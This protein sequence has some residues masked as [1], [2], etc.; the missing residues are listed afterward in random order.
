MNEPF[1]TSPQP[2]PEHPAHAYFARRDEEKRSLKRQS[3]RAGICAIA[4]LLLEH[5]LSF[6][7]VGSPLFALYEQSET[8]NGIIEMFFYL[9]CMFCPF[10]VAYCLMRQEDRQM[11]TLFEKPTSK[12]AAAAAVVAGLLICS[13]ANY[14]TNILISLMENAGISV[15]GGVYDTPTTGVSLVYSL[16]TIGILP[17]F[18]E[19]FALRGIVMQPLRRHGDRFAI[20]MSACVFGLLH[21]NLSQ[22]LFAFIV[23]LA[24]GF[25]VVETGS[26]WV[27][28][29][30]HMLNNVESVVLNYLLETRPTAAERFYDIE[31][32]IL[33]VFGALCFVLFM[34]ICTR[35][36]LQ[37]DTGVLT[38][39]EKTAAY[40]FTLPMVIAVIAL[41][42]ETVW[43]IHFLGT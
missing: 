18:V 16:L 20:V 13:G 38:A 7:L 40:V 3:I 30:I 11:L 19:E 26:V 23:G 43:Q 4:F 6:L 33:L 41:V 14:L 5:V 25:F 1:Y 10:A 27:G 21:G 36:R 29:A 22:F 39:G 37:K 35:N 15:D 17:A 8:A 32:S 24:I 12:P 34:T 42:V 9:L 2:E 28:V 31:M